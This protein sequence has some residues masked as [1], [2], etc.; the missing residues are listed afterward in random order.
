[1][2]WTVDY[3]GDHQY[4]D[5]VG[6][7]TYTPKGGAGQAVNCFPAEINRSDLTGT[8]GVS[9]SDRV[10]VVW[11]ITTGQ[12]SPQGDTLLFDSVTYSIIGAAH[13]GDD[14]QHRLIC[15]KQVS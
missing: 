11:G 4:V 13:R 12:A 10:F 14:A 8:P 1:M 6:A 3:S 9:P 5:G 2:A 7:G 15:R